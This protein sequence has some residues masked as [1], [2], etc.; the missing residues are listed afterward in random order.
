[1]GSLSITATIDA[2]NKSKTK[3]YEIPDQHIA[4][5]H[6]SFKYETID[7]SDG[8]T[9]LLERSEGEAFEA[10]ILWMIDLTDQRVRAIEQQEILKTIVSLSLVDVTPPDPPPDPPPDAP[11]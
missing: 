5:V 1:M 10:W 11:V 3:V 6:N 8:T 4:R 2:L 7:H 9:T